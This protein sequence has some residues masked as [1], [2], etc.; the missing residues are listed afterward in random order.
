MSI[1]II[2]KLQPTRK[3]THGSKGVPATSADSGDRDDL[4]AQQILEPVLGLPGGSVGTVLVVTINLEPNSKCRV[5]LQYYNGL[6]D[7]ITQQIYEDIDNP[8]ITENLIYTLHWNMLANTSI[9]LLESLDL[10]AV[11]N[12]PDAGFDLVA[13]VTIDAAIVS[14]SVGGF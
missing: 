9:I 6:Q 1:T 4:V 3:F 10:S 7:V 2:D 5:R 8:S 12:S 11:I 13:G 14:N